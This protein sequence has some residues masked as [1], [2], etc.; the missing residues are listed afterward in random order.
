[1]MYIEKGE[2]IK[3]KELIKK[4]LK[5]IKLVYDETTIVDFTDINE[6]I[7]EYITGVHLTYIN[8]TAIEELLI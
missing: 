5:N 7:N 8:K 6:Y 2:C 3:G 1:M 4:S